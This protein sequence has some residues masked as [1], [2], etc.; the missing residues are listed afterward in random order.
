MR[1]WGP[2]PDCTSGEPAGNSDPLIAIR[3]ACM[4][5]ASTT[6]LPATALGEALACI[7]VDILDYRISLLWGSMVCGGSVTVARSLSC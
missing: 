5:P 1:S 7:E 4:V 6:E 2:D 3:S